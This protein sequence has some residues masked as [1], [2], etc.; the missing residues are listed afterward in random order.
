MSR[1]LHREPEIPSDA[2]EAILVYIIR[3]LHTIGTDAGGRRF[4]ESSVY[5]TRKQDV[6]AVNSI[7]VPKNMTNRPYIET[8]ISVPQ[9]N[10]M[11]RT[12]V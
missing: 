12:Y 3:M 9:R 4:S 1:K 2:L 5:F 11:F 7:H 10:S 6:T 8:L